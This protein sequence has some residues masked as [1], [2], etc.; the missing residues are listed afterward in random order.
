MLLP[1]TNIAINATETQ[2]NFI[3]LLLHRSVF[4]PEIISVNKK[5]PTEAVKEKVQ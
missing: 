3:T 2:M 1:V 4:Y 5:I